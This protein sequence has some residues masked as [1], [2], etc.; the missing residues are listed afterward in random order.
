MGIVL[1]RNL[2]APSHL[3]AGEFCLDAGLVLICCPICGEV[4][5]LD[6]ERHNIARDGRVTPAWHCLACP[7]HEWL[8]LEPLP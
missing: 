8:T 3:L 1:R 7:A 5:P 2:G 4:T 6:D